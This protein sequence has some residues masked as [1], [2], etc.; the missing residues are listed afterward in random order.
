MWTRSAQLSF[1]GLIIGLGGVMVQDGDAVR[2][3]G[4]FQG[5]TSVTWM[6]IGMQAVGG[7]IV[8]VVM[9]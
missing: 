8:A 9:R 6:A 1:F 4:F 3:D 2:A 7:L 5:Y